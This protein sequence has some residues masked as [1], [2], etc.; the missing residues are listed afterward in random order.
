MRSEEEFAALCREEGRNQYR[1]LREGD[2][3][4]RAGPGEGSNLLY[5]SIK[6]YE[7]RKWNIR[8]WRQEK[9][10]DVLRNDYEILEVLLVLERNMASRKAIVLALLDVD[11]VN[12]V[13]VK[14]DGGAGVVVYNGWP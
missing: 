3:K 10:L 14:D 2:P 13:E 11:G 9:E 4:K 8:V 6:A 12:A 5:E 7:C 1:G